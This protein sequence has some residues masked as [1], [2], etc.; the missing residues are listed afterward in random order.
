MLLNK[1]IFNGRR[2][3]KPGTVELMTTVNRLPEKNAGGDGF[4]FGLGFELYN[5]NIKIVPEVSNSAYRWG[6]LYGTE[7]IIDPENNMFALFYLNMPRRDSL[8]PRFL[9]KAYGLFDN[10]SL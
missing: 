5:E 2:V 6:G 9:S 4:Q 8:Y 1:G 3:L 10:S 7:Y